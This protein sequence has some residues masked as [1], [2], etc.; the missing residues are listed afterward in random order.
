MY[1]AGVERGDV[2]GLSWYTTGI[3]VMAAYTRAQTTTADKVMYATV[4]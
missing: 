4:W 2:Y 1:Q 3:M